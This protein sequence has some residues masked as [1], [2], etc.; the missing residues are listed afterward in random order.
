M[1]TVLSYSIISGIVLLFCYLPYRWFMA[2][3][4]QYLFNRLT[5]YAIYGLSLISPLIILY[6]LSTSRNVM[7]AVSIGVSNYHILDSSN[8]TTDGNIPIWEILLTAYTAGMVFAILSYLLGIGKILFIIGKSRRIKDECGENIVVSD[9]DKISPFNWGNCIVINSQMY[10]SED[11]LMIIAH[12]SAHIRQIHWLDLLF[13]QI[14]ICIH[15]Y[16]PVAWALRDCIKELHEFQ[17]DE[18]V[19]DQGFNPQRYQMFLVS[20]SF[21]SKF[22]LPAD[23]LNDGNI[24]RRI[25]MMNE[26]KTNNS[27]RL[28][29]LTL[30]PF[31]SIGL[32]ACSLSPMRFFVDQIHNT[33]FYEC[34]SNDNTQKSINRPNISEEN[35]TVYRIAKDN[36][37]KTETMDESFVE[38]EYVGGG[39]ALMKFLM[40]NVKYPKEAEIQ[41]IEGEVI[42]S[43]QLSDEGDVMSVHISKSVC[44]FLDNEALRVC[45]GITKFKPAL[46]NGSPIASIYDLPIT[47]KI[48]SDW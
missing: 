9:N 1:G 7:N 44:N 15:W 30:L 35:Q 5:I 18:S 38:A 37:I 13:S 23:F 29:I 17:A 34:H 41:H 8:I 6:D 39:M 36:V 19:L 3:R 4:K 14:M 43:F 26:I 16:N 12:E 11:R 40:D 45:K 32:L 27:K 48:A 31:L 24:R 42:V 21:S 2:N 28:A 46:L 22:N 33:Y 25:Y 10:E 47:F 20:K